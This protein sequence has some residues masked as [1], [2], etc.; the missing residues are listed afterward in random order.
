MG[1]GTQAARHGLVAASSSLDLSRPVQNA[2]AAGGDLGTRLV[3][4]SR[5]VRQRTFG[6]LGGFRSTRQPN[7]RGLAA[8]P[9]E[10]RL[11]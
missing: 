10:L 1:T 6:Y 5:P 2:P 9:V 4:V 11:M 8:A 3:V 7:P